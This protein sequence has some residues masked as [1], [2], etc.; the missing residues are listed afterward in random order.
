[1]LA[2]VDTDFDIYNSDLGVACC[3]TMLCISGTTGAYSRGCGVL[4][5]V[6]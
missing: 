6:S 3:T 1:M 5:E 4:A 2:P